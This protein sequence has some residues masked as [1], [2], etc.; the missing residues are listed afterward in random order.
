MKNVKPLESSESELDAVINKFSPFLK[1]VKKRLFFTFSVFIVTTIIGFVFYE[2]IIKFLIDI[3]GLK[4]INIVFT[5]PFQFINLATSCGIVVG[6]MFVAPLLISQILS[7]LKPALRRKEFKKVIGLLPFSIILFLIGFV[8]GALIM[9]WQ[10]QIFLARS[11][12][13]GIGNLLDISKLLTTVLLT[14]ALMGIGFQLPILLLL[15]MFVGI[16]DR[17]QLSKYRSWVYLGS[18]IFAILLPADSIIADILLALPF[19]FLFELTLISSYLSK[20]GKTDPA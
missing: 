10:I 9:R 17:Q 6:L 13:L 12:S 8:F 7:F 2:K 11:V 18:F 5:S 15:L 3:L 14:S 16:I 19:I 1:E 4:G 20:R